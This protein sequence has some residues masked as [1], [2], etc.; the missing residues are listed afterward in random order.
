MVESKARH[1]QHD[2]EEAITVDGTQ[3][4]CC[5]RH[6]VSMSIKPTLEA[7]DATASAPIAIVPTLPQTGFVRQ[8]QLLTII[9]V[10]RSRLW[11]YV[12]AGT[13]PAPVKLSAGVIAWR[14][15]DVRHWIAT[16][17]AAALSA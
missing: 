5:R 15:E 12:S 6:N 3:A 14:A 13:F 4:L 10:S 17:G 8:T 9:P 11:R 1:F 16:K 7:S 2:V